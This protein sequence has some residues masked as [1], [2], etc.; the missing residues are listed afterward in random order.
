M[1]INTLRQNGRHFLDDILKCIFLNENVQISIK[2]ALNFALKAPLNSIP[3]LVQIV[4]W[5]PF[6]QQAIIWTNDGLFTKA[7]MHHLDSMT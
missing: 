5:C 3:A 4:A 7:Y 1:K 6:R 2:I